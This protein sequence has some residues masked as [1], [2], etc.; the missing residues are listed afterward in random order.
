[1]LPEPT[2]IQP[3][4]Q[5]ML[6]QLPDGILLYNKPLHLTSFGL[7]KKLKRQLQVKK[8]GHGGTL[9]PLAS[10]LMIIGVEKGTKLLDKYLK[11][12]KKYEGE[13]ILGAVTPSYDLET[14]PQNF[15]DVS[16]ISQESLNKLIPQFSGEILQKPPMFSALKKNGE[17]MYRLARKGLNI[18]LE[19]RT[20]T[21]FELQLEL[22]S[23]PL[24]QFKVYCS[25]GTYIRSLV[26]DIG[27]QLGTGAYLSKLVRTSIGDFNL[28]QSSALS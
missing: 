11:L 16:K 21:I 9:D 13:F 8:I 2:K 5:T 3:F 20:V 7:V 25:S 24:I 1:M 10:G 15:K 28:D 17:T 22:T 27:Q 14:I 4:N 6:P 26:Y 19:P 18:E 12:A 23:L